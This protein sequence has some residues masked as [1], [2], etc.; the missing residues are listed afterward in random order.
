MCVCV[1]AHK[2]GTPSEGSVRCTSSPPNSLPTAQ[3]CAGSP[4][5]SFV[6]AGA[7]GSQV[8]KGYKIQAWQLPHVVICLCLILLNIAEVFILLFLSQALFYLTKAKV[9]FFNFFW[10]LGD[11]F[12]GL[13]YL[14]LMGKNQ[15]KFSCYLEVILCQNLLA[16]MK[17]NP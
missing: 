2:P 15:N 3:S 14:F 5:H 6:R 1:C 16:L 8:V 10:V 13:F 12:F 7:G 11:G 4:P 17:E 9:G